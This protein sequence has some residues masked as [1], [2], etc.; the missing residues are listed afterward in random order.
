LFFVIFPHVLYVCVCVCVFA[1]ISGVCAS[2]V[3][4]NKFHVFI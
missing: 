3:G 1:L 2:A 4:C